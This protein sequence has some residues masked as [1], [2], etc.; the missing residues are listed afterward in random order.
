MIS[1][2]KPQIVLV[3]GVSGSGKST[4]GAALAAR[5]GWAF[6]DADDFHPN[7]NREKMAR[8]EALN[9]TD[10]E[11]W[12]QRLHELLGQTLLGQ[13]LLGQTLLGQTQQQNQNGLVLACSALKVSYREILIGTLEGVKIVSLEGSRELIAE[14]MRNRDHFMPVSLLENQ[15]A[16]LEPPTDAIIVDIGLPIETMLEQVAMRLGQHC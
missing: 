13:T 15:L 3:M 10:R 6:A 14:R 12:L 16:T 8:G 9:D 11:P 4:F 1:R 2:V 5:Q 7:A